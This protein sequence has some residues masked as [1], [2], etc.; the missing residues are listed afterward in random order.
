MTVDIQNTSS[1]SGWSSYVLGRNGERKDATL[2]KGD[3]V[4]ADKITESLDYKSGDTVRFVI[5]FDKDDNVTQEQGREIV[6]E[7]FAEFMHG[8]REDEYLLDIVEHTDTDHLHYHGR[9][10]KLNLLTQTQ[11]KLY[12]HKSDLGFKK[13]IID[14]LA[15]KHGLVTGEQKRRLIPDPQQRVK[16]INE[17]RREHGQKPFDLSS[18]KGRGEAEERLG[19][20]FTEA[21]KSG[22]VDNLDE[23]KA[24][25]EALGFA[26]VKEGFDKGK[27]FH[28]LTIENDSGKLR[29]KGDIYG[30][31]FYRHSRED[32][33]KAIINNQ[34]IREGSGSDRPSRSDI[35]RTLQR[36]RK[37]RLQF[38]DK[39]YS[40]ARKRAYERLHKATNG[41]KKEQHQDPKSPAK[42]PS[43]YR[44]IDRRNHRNIGNSLL[45]QGQREDQPRKDRSGERRHEVVQSKRNDRGEVENDRVREQA[46]KRV[47]AIRARQKQERREL[48]TA[49]RALRAEH[50]RV[51]EQ[52]SVQISRELDKATTEREQ[53]AGEL[54]SVLRDAYRAKPTDYQAIAEA[55]HERGYRREIIRGL[56]A[57]IQR[58]TIGISK[59]KHLYDRRAKGIVG[60]FR[61]RVIKAGK[62]KTMQELNHFKST[63]NLAEYAQSFGY[64][65]NRKKSTKISPVLQQKDGDTLVVGQDKKD[66]HY[67][68]FN[69]NNDSD[70]GTV[71]DFVQKRTGETLGK[72]RKRLRQWLGMPNP[73]VERVQV[74]PAA[75]DEIELGMAKEKAQKLW[76]SLSQTGVSLFRGELRGIPIDTV[77]TAKDSVRR[78]DQGNWY[79]ALRDANGEICGVEKRDKDGRNARIAG[80]GQKKGIFAFGGQDPELCEKIIVT[81]STIDALSAKYISD[82]STHWT[83]AFV[84]IGG[85]AGIVA[86]KAIKEL[87]DKLPKAE[88]I[89]ATDNDQAGDRHAQS[90]MKIIG[91]GR[92]YARHRPQNKDLNDDLQQIKVQRMAERQQNNR[93]LNRGRGGMSR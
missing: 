19:D 35:D 79:F 18:K 61:D 51:I 63:I 48:Q 37:K 53:R 54:G 88:I 40:G 84:S 86:Q 71:L 23:I 20:Y 36:E 22:F 46:I 58:T 5:S 13:A 25:L 73:Q 47:R 70:S 82:K 83:H 30:T 64:E 81:E 14:K 56:K 74:Q 66:G 49:Q 43:P 92:N 85:N 69:V 90:L 50:Q 60:Q 55:T 77:K 41:V 91:K 9:I 34:S 78:D 27:E 45:L 39:Q 31:E 62:E 6:K 3:T 89:F 8:F 42:S 38:I 12:W 21:V 28:Y 26:V 4:L 11:L 80:A 72:V 59:I 52:F 1:G 44:P 32:R 33:T 75:L 17:W 16:Q 7:F 93:S 65:I 10:P 29:I 24:E 76:N 67:I 87:C 57:I 68:Y 2:I 15:E